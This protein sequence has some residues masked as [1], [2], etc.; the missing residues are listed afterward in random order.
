MARLRF[1]AISVANFHDDSMEGIV[2][3]DSIKRRG[4]TRRK[5]RISLQI[6]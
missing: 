6:F 4:L 3:V 2:K 5:N 1:F